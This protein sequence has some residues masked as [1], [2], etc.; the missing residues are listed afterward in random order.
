MEIKDWYSLFNIY[1]NIPA[2]NANTHTFMSDSIIPFENFLHFFQ[3]Y[4]FVNHKLNVDS[5]HSYLSLFCN[6]SLVSSFEL[7]QPN[8]GFEIISFPF[9]NSIVFVQ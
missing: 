3:V 7:I 4:C 5:S 1:K 2:D 8:S 9:D 6:T